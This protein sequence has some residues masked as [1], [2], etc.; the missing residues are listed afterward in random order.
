MQQI[1]QNSTTELSTDQY[2]DHDPDSKLPP[3]P[4][5]LFRVATLFR[6]LVRHLVRPA[7]RSDHPANPMDND[8]LIHVQFRVYNG[9]LIDHEGVTRLRDMNSIPFL[10]RRQC[11]PITKPSQIT[12]QKLTPNHVLQKDRSVL[13]EIASVIR[14]RLINW[15]EQS[16]R[17]SPILKPQKLHS[18]NRT[19]QRIP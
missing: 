17:S 8:P 3:R 16:Q 5:L 1:D 18:E 15:S 7:L 11:R 13:A 19:H 9:D 12:P 14:H 2:E 10:V 4:S 6:P